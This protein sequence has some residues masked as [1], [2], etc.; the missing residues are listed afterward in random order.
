MALSTS[1]P[2][3]HATLFWTYDQLKLSS[4]ISPVQQI[5][6][7]GDQLSQPSMRAIS[8]NATLRNKSLRRALFILWRRRRWKHEAPT[9]EVKGIWRSQREKKGGILITCQP[10]HHHKYH[11]FPSSCFM[12]SPSDV[13]D[14]N[15][16]GSREK[17]K[18]KKHTKKAE[19]KKNIHL[20]R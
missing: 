12:C 18:E 9:D 8:P 14:W 3:L 20:K 16:K 13:V 10:R 17:K 6:T 11:H 4:S 1:A 7:S 15:A 2:A 5:F 19:N